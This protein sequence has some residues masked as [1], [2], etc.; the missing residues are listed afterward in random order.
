MQSHESS[1]HP[2][3]PNPS[4]PSYLI[5]FS[6]RKWRNP[7]GASFLKRIK[8]RN[9]VLHP[10]SCIFIF[11]LGLQ[12]AVQHVTRCSC[13]CSLHFCQFLSKFLTKDGPTSGW[14]DFRHAVSK[15]LMSISMCSEDKIQW[16]WHP[17]HPQE[18]SSN[19]TYKESIAENHSRA[20]SS[21]LHHGNLFMFWASHSTPASVPPGTSGC[22]QEDG[23]GNRTSEH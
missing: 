12:W 2:E 8:N 5:L 10:A 15:C 20:T 11:S 17:P 9:W 23:S 6:K 7:P 21:T 22:S 13:C 4:D 16:P 18:T 14:P 19:Q 3:T 1:W